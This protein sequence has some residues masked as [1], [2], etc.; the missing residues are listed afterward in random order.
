MSKCGTGRC[1]SIV[2][3]A[4]ILTDAHRAPSRPSSDRSASAFS[5]LGRSGHGIGLINLAHQGSK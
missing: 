3:T 1:Q 4:P 2:P 5:I